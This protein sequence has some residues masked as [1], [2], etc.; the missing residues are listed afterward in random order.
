MN[1]YFLAHNVNRL[2]A[3][4]RF[5]PVD[6]IAGTMT[7]LMAAS[8]ELADEL[9]VLAKT[10]DTT[11]VWEIP[12]PEYVERLK[13]KSP[14]LSGLTS[15]SP[16]RQLPPAPIKGEG[17]VVVQGSNV[18]ALQATQTAA[19][20]V[21]IVEVKPP[22]PPLALSSGPPAAGKKGGK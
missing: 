4:V 7:G 1:K 15:W 19:E 13:K 11:A 9:G 20:A 8:G 10:P 22:A 3:G 6:V 12:E 5:E 2:I 17:A 21:E 14:S 16:P 18:H